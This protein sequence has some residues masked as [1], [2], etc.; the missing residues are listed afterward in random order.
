MRHCTIIGNAEVLHVSR[1]G[2]ESFHILWG[3]GHSNVHERSNV[4]I[5]VRMR[6]EGIQTFSELIIST[7]FSIG[8]GR[9]IRV[10]WGYYFLCVTPFVL[11]MYH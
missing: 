2:K 7:K 8:I 11:N 3:N 4:A 5:L 6:M 1:Q 10:I 9:C